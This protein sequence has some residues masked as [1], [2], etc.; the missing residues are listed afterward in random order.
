LAQWKAQLEEKVTAWEAER[1]TMQ[2]AHTEEL[3]Q[4]KS[5]HQAA[6]TAVQNEIVALR[7]QHQQEVD[8]IRLEHDMLVAEEREQQAQALAEVDEMHYMERETIQKDRDLLAARVEELT[9]A[10]SNGTELNAQL[11][12]MRSEHEMALNEKLVVI[13]RLEMEIT[14]VMKE[15]R[16]LSQQVD[17]LKSELERLQLAQTHISADSSKRESL[18]EELDRHRSV[19]GDLQIDLQRTKDAM[20]NLQAEKARQE[21]LLK[22]LQ[23]QLVASA[24]ASEAHSAVDSHDHV[25]T[26]RATRV[27]GVPPSKPPPPGAPPTLPNGMSK[28]NFGSMSSRSLTLSTLHSPTDSMVGPSTAATSILTPSV[29]HDHTKLATQL[30]D[31]L[32]QVE[33]QDTMIKTLNKQ[34]T[35]CEG[36]LQAHMDLVN[37]LES[38]LNDS[39]RNLRKARLQATEIARE[40]DNLQH[41]LDGARNE[42]QDAKREVVNVRMSIVE[43]KQSLEQR[44]D[45]E[46]RAKERARAQLDSRMEELAKR[47]S[48]F[49]CM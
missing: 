24:A 29:T 34:L 26:P 28:D 2:K 25:M 42:L 16:E 48:K 27:N 32:R 13:T 23:A 36:D 12:Q 39:E 1:A 47:K 35:H 44:L 37:T 46:R 31:A 19:I 49:A 21:L 30:E 45:E 17:V 5:N 18:V 14:T 43:E 8:E 6:M 40:R 33:E 11:Q 22:E 38:S 3:L 7:E 10:G 20:D 4:V 41:Q 15:R 9:T